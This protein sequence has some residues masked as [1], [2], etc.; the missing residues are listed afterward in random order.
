[1]KFSPKKE[2]SQFIHSFMVTPSEHSLKWETKWKLGTW[3]YSL[4]FAYKVNL[5][6][7]QVTHLIM[8]LPPLNDIH[9]YD[10][11]LIY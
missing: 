1:M 5:M 2:H 9:K 11:S 7:K 10:Q 3:F 6:N 4:S 8:A